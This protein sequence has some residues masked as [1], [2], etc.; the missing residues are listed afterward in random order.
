MK[1]K[2]VIT[3][4]ALF[5]LIQTSYFWE[6]WIGFLLFPISLLI[7][8]TFIVLVVNL[9][10]KLWALLK[11]K[12]RNKKLLSSFI[13]QAV[14][15]PLTIFFPFGMIN[16]NDFEA[17]DII[18][19]FRE[20]VGGCGSHLKFKVDKTYIDKEVCFGSFER[21]GKYE[22]KGDTIT[23]LSGSENDYA[24]I[25]RGKVENELVCFKN[26]SVRII[27]EITKLELNQK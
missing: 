4:I 16:F 13:I 22:I 21:S 12:F 18:L 25:K 10:S 6:K 3:S 14:I 9:F 5:V 17:K 7:I 1:D 15:L 26:D 8:V 11:N 2:Y 27:Y 23:F 24:V 19:A 20:G